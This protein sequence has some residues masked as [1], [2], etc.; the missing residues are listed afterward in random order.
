MSGPAR[1]CRRPGGLVL[2]GLALLGV[3]LGGCA[4]AFE[5]SEAPGP[6]RVGRLAVGASSRADVVQ[7]LG[8]PR[9]RGVARLAGMDR[10]R[11]ILFYD[12]YRSDGQRIDMTF[13]IVFLDGDRYDGHLSMSS[14]E[15]VEKVE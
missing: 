7:A 5:V 14:S 1:P 8:E 13:L 9:G 15:L 3:G 6:A 11:T 10:P 2:L 12:A 4:P